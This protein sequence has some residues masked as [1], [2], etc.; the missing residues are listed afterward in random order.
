MRSVQSRLLLLLFTVASAFLVFIWQWRERELERIALL[1]AD[2]ASQLAHSCDQ[3]FTLNGKS[4][5][6][7]ASDYTY[8]DELASFVTTQ[9]RQWALE[10]LETC[11]ETY[12]VDGVW[13]FDNEKQQVYWSHSAKL[14][15]FAPP[16]AFSKIFELFQKSKLIHFYAWSDQGLIEYR[17][18]TIHSS[19]D[20]HRK[21][22]IFGYFLA[23]RL[24]DSAFT[25][26]LASQSGCDVIV[27]AGPIDVDRLVEREPGT[28]RCRIDLDGV[29]DLPTAT[30][31][32]K[33]HR[34]VYSQFLS[35]IEHTL[36]YFLGFCAVSLGLL[37]AGIRGWIITPLSKLQRAIGT[38]TEAP[39]LSLKRKQD[40][41]GAIGRLMS[42]FFLQRSILEA[43]VSQ[44]QIAEERAEA[45][46]QA[47]SMFLANMS[48]ELRTPLNGIAGMTHILE[49]SASDDEQQDCIRTIRISSDHLL[50]II[51]E[52]LDF[53][54]IEAGKMT[55]ENISFDIAEAIE[56][57]GEMLA[58][59]AH[60]KRIVLNTFVDENLPLEMI[61][62]PVKIKQILTNLAGNAIKFTTEGAVTIRALKAGHCQFRIEVQDTGI[63]IPKEKLD[64]VFESFTQADGTTT[65]QFGGTGLGLTITK[66]LVEL[67]GG[68][69]GVL[70]ELGMGS[71]FYC[72]FPI[73][74]VDVGSNIQPMELSYRFIGSNEVEESLRLALSRIGYV[75]VISD[76]AD[77]CFI[78]ETPGVLEQPTGSASFSKK[79]LLV[80]RGFPAPS[81]ERS[82]SEYDAIVNLPIR[83]NSLQTA[84]NQV[85]GT[86]K[87]LDVDEKR[88][89]L[90]VLVAEDNDVN[91]KVAKRVLE[92]FGCQVEIASDGEGALEL[93]E[94]HSFDVVFMDCQMPRMDG[95]AA[96]KAIRSRD[97]KWSRIPIIAMT[98]N[99]LEGDRRRCLDAG[100]D[101]YIAKPIDPEELEKL[102]AF[103]RSS[104][105]HGQAA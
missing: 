29:S 85:S 52:I 101:D 95:F 4:I 37:Y 89:C 72:S 69:I 15:A 1:R 80:R 68:E 75:P 105:D 97:A 66:R 13:V 34:P 50:S 32:F 98:A 19:A 99:A 64:A 11:L 76:S 6:T 7:L 53:S 10:N 82:R 104:L 49:D 96:T 59:R 74:S 42:E 83:R 44:R 60:E 102:L 67:M 40:E 26:S 27:A 46:N 47:K 94:R 90:R 41:F 65:R 100:M 92:K 17:G 48:H 33:V 36:Y 35:A 81:S 70:S 51:N 45:A 8:W 84:I 18:A 86:Q 23:G 77:F 2:A 61:G 58:I 57:V 5:Q 56:D 88:A 71:T 79:I 16:A 24:L 73:Q 25:N 62:D 12:S 3:L 9:D 21:G 93:L 31:V 38:L 39:I 63:G 54:K 28:F 78:E 20:R 103:Y 91:Q 14:N 43:E 22:K 55:I 87:T 30:I